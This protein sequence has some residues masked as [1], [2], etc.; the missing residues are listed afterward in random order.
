MKATMIWDRNILTGGTDDP[1]NGDPVLEGRHAILRIELPSGHVY[2]F[3]TPDRHYSAVVPSIIKEII[4]SLNM[5]RNKGV[6]Y[7]QQNS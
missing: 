6:Y 3:K 5:V 7:A 4:D 2:H 1:H